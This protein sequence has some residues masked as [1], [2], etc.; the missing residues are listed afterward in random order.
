MKEKTRSKVA[1]GCA[2]FDAESFSW[3]P[4][5]QGMC[6][7]SLP[8]EWTRRSFAQ[9]ACGLWCSGV[10]GKQEIIDGI[11]RKSELIFN[12]TKAVLPTAK[13]IYYDYG[14]SYWLPT[15]ST[16]G[17]FN[18]PP[19]C[20]ERGDGPGNPGAS[21]PDGWCTDLGFTLDES[22]LHDPNFMGLAFSAY[23][24]CLLRTTDIVLRS[25]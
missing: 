8:I 12:V 19:G 16:D 7:R 5:Y 15:G 13:V 17:C 20:S 14:A 23:W 25:R 18:L 22:F 24:P 6:T 3:S 10:A 9:I 21:C 4:N 11:R 1:I 2:Q